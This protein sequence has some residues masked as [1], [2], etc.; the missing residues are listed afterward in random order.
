[1]L[2]ADNE[3]PNVSHIVEENTGELMYRIIGASAQQ[4][5]RLA[6]NFMSR[7]E[8]PE[9]AV[10]DALALTGARLQWSALPCHY[11]Q[12]SLKSRD[13]TCGLMEAV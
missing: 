6:I 8:Y 2:Y 11:I 7:V 12:K 13:Y 4:A 10:K 1:M 5:G 3:T 9:D